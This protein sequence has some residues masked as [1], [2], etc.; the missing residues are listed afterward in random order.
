MDSLS[1]FFPA[2]NEEENIGKVVAEAVSFLDN[3]VKDYEIIIVNDGSTDRT[4]EIADQLAKDSKIRVVHHNEK[5]GYGKALATG[6]KSATKKF[7][8]Y[9]DSD[10]QF[11]IQELANFIPFANDHDLV[12]GYRK[13]RNDTFTRKLTSK[14]YN[15][16]SNN[17]LGLRIKDCNC[18]FKLCRRDIFDNIKLNTKRS[19]DV[20]LLAKARKNNLE[21]KQ[22]PVGHFERKKGKSEAT[23][24]FN[25]ISPKLVITSLKELRQIKSDV[26]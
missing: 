14:V 9:T 22:V 7:V 25:L 3:N 8:F 17:Y 21:I 20:E 5:K 10:K 13:K 2:Y 6:F 1:V 15:F 19:V 16:I 18:A 24:Y 4:G 11:D 12:V 26:K 23:T